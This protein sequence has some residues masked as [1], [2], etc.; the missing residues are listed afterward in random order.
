[1]VQDTSILVVGPTIIAEEPN[2]MS[3]LPKILVAFTVDLLHDVVDTNR[4]FNELVVVRVIILGWTLDEGPNNI[5][6]T[7][8][9]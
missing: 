6:A 9:F 5:A 1:L 4:I 8:I 7:F 3:E 2:I